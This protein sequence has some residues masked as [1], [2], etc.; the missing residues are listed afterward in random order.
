MKKTVEGN[1]MKPLRRNPDNSAHTRPVTARSVPD[2]APANRNMPQTQRQAQRPVQNTAQRPVQSQRTMQGQPQRPVQKTAQRTAQNA[3]QGPVRQ[4]NNR[5]VQ[6]APQKPVQKSAQRPAQKPAQNPVRKNVPQ[7]AQKPAVKPAPQKEKTNAK[8]FNFMPLLIIGVSALL[9]FLVYYGV[10]SFLKEQF[11][12]VKQEITIEAGSPKPDLN[13]YLEGEPAFMRFVSCNLDFDEVDGN[14]PQTVRF[15]INMYGKNFPCTL[16]I[17]DTVAPAGQGVPQKLFASQELPD[18]MTCVSDVSDVTDVTAR[19]TDVPDYSAGG[20]YNAYVV[21]SDVSGNET[22]I[23]VPLDVTKDSTPP[24]IKGYQDLQV[25]I[26]DSVAYRKNLII[27]DDYDTAPALDIDTSKVD[28][29]TPGKYEVTYTARDF[30]GNETSVSV[31]LKVENK[32]KGYIEPD[33]VYAEA[34]KILDEITEPG[35]TEEEVALQIVWWCRYNIRFILRTTSRSW[36]EAAYNAYTKR[37]GN[38]YST[39][40]AVKVLLDVAGIEN[41]IIERYPYQTATHYWNYVKL[42]GQ[43]YHCDAT[44][45]QGYDSYFFMYTTKELLDFW[46]GGWNGFQFKQK[47]FPESATESVQK[48]IDYKNHKIKTG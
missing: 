21:L 11:A 31:K 9:V 6:R 12:L 39:V 14:L 24:V 20:K 43:W 16:N 25:Y 47:V 29:K 28:L 42:N 40:Y 17:K 32:P 22:Y 15:N 45:R 30:S 46:Q 44:W 3:L 4:G 10:S 18:P 35:M 5:P 38:C 41:M 8:P 7:K 34:K 1:N 48:R 23:T 27:T 37:M 26:G 19:W 2:K 36:T 13:S 33:Q